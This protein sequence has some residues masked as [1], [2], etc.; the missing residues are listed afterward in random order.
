MS[1]VLKRSMDREG[2]PMSKRSRSGYGPEHDIRDRLSPSDFERRDSYGGSRGKYDPRDAPPGPRPVYRSEFLVHD[3]PPPRQFENR[4]PPQGA[5]YQAQTRWLPENND[6]RSLYISGIPSK[7]PD[8]IVRDCLID[9]YKRFGEM[10]VKITM[11]NDQRVA[12]LNFRYPEDAREALMNGIKFLFD[13]ELKIN[14]VFNKRRNLSPSR[15]ILPPGGSNSGRL[16]TDPSFYSRHS[17][18][19]YDRRPPPPDVPPYGGRDDYRT[20]P[21]P[22]GSL[23]PEGERKS[24]KFPYHLDHVDPEY[25]DK[26]TR[27]LFVGNL[28]VNITDFDLRNIFGKF[29]MVEDV[30]IKRPI[31]NTGNAFAFIKYIN[32]DC[33][34]RAK[35]EMSGKYIG[36]F[37]CKI[38]Y[39]KVTPTTVV[40]VG[41]LGP[42]VTVET[43]E[44]E[45]DRFGAIVHIEWPR[46]KNFAYVVYDSIDAA[47]AACQQMRGY[48]LGGPERRLRLDF[49]EKD[50]ISRSHSLPDYHYPPP[51]DRTY[52]PPPERPPGL[53]RETPRGP[54]EGPERQRYEEWQRENRDYRGPP[55]EAYR[56]DGRRHDEYHYERRRE[57][58]PDYVKGPYHV[59]APRS[60]E[61]ARGDYRD[62]R[63]PSREEERHLSERRDY[64][65]PSPNGDF[66][67]NQCRTLADL[68][69]M[70]PV[71]WNG[72]LILKSSAFATRMHVVGGDVTLVDTLMR[73][74]TSTESP[75]LKITQRL[76]LDQPKLDDVGRRIQ[77]AG[78]RGHCIL[79]AMPSSLTNYED[80][81]API[82]QRPLKNLVTYL[83]QK[84][85]AGV[86]SLPPI[87]IQGKKDVGVLHAFPPCDFGFN[88]LRNRAPKLS[89][90][91]TKEDYLVVVVVNG[92]A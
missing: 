76:R 91:T 84:E 36:R 44:R 65:A 51:K 78:P 62:D 42:W 92:A 53:W 4:A 57:R 33:A 47:Q 17:P 89:P 18:P 87:P 74:P 20:G 66:I 56:D 46:N 79:L 85:A 6:Y 43:L 54:L 31:R 60:P 58:T 70:L 38:G 29:G 19:P 71:A 63:G 16:P 25:D 34:H 50:H 39:G 11:S 41:G 40:W 83:K 3:G 30:D 61:R 49:G 12:Y 13:R 37:Q 72:A 24:E 55:P 1:S 81:A 22:P 8:Q 2:S 32:L 88:F 28:D 48:P 77:V 27:T 7:V 80:S 26:A 5:P 15:N 68:A 35:V 23:P 21:P 9:N 86:I 69:K 75:V 10:N 14:P 45:F 59:G 64:R 90:E 52:G 82:Q 67:D 73:D